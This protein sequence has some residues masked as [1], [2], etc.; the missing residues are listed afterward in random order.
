MSCT[1]WRTKSQVVSLC[2][3]SYI[4]MISIPHTVMERAEAIPSFYR[5]RTETEKGN[6]HLLRSLSNDNYMLISC[7]PFHGWSWILRRWLWLG[8]PLLS[9]GWF[10]SCNHQT[11]R[12]YFPQHSW[13]NVMLCELWP[14]PVETTHV[15]YP[16]SNSSGHCAVVVG[17][18]GRIPKGEDFQTDLYVIFKHILPDDPPAWRVGNMNY[19]IQNLLCITVIDLS[20]IWSFL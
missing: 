5:N 16:Y 6:R 9:F 18:E 4:V 11:P 13:V 15:L 17:I 8:K 19:W 7:K 2:C 10:T 20:G 1:G 3:R 12:E 14:H